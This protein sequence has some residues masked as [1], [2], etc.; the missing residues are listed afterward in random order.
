M[1]LQDHPLQGPIFLLILFSQRTFNLHTVLSLGSHMMYG[2]ISGGGGVALFAW[3]ETGVELFRVH[4]EGGLKFFPE[5][6]PKI[7]NPPS[8]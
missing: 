1:G 6:G 5:R 2:K 3:R 7:P 4:R 8:W